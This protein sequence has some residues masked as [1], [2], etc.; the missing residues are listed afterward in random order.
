MSPIRSRK[1]AL[2]GAKGL[3]SRGTS[4]DSSLTTLVESDARSDSESEYSPE[5][6]LT[7]KKPKARPRAQALISRGTKSI[8]FGT[9]DIGG[10]ELRPTVVFDALWQWMQERMLIDKKRR[11]GIPPPWTDDHILRDYF[12]CAPYRVADRATQYLITEVIEKGPQSPSEVVFRVCIFSTFTKIETWEHLQDTIGPLRWSNY[13][14]SVYQSALR[15]A[16]KNGRTIYTGAYQKPA[17]KFDFDETFMNHLAL[18]EMW[19]QLELPQLLKDADYLADVY[20]WLISFPGMGEFNTYQLLLNLSYTPVSHF[21]D[22][23]FVVAGIGA[24]S[25]L[26]K[27]F[28]D[29]Y[30]IAKENSDTIDVDVMQWMVDNQAECFKKLGINFVGL[31]PDSLPLTLPD[32][33]HSICE[34][35]KY[36]RLA[37]PHVKGKDNRTNLRRSYKQTG[38]SLP[39][40]RLPKAWS[41]PARRKVRIRP[42]PPPVIEKRYLI[43]AIEGRRDTPDG[44]Q[45]LVYWF[46]Y[47]ANMATWEPEEG[48]LLDAPDVVADYRK[49]GQ[50]GIRR[51]YT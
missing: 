7:A 3:G 47:P 36:A 2:Y 46:G 25:G 51:V 24:K 45:Y 14:R 37:F 6:Q 32:I 30:K 10:Q 48:L 16:Q 17:P 11:S 34:V 22:N 29:S 33:E 13:D 44:P 28:G 27:L 43:Q 49:Y 35:D 40:L 38:K 12:F 26:V 19:M 9:L 41:H 4:T 1:G 23:D 42:G 21:S 39:P 8:V 5:P 31:G 50:S 15:T 20:E 18:V